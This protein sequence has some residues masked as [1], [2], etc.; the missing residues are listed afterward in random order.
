MSKKSK[1]TSQKPTEMEQPVAPA[2]EEPEPEPA[3]TPEPQAFD[4]QT[5]ILRIKAT[6]MDISAQLAELTSS[7]KPMRKATTNGK[8]QIR[9]NCK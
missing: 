5:E 2:K 7:R 4:L 1:K 6:L 3:S 8:C 9:S